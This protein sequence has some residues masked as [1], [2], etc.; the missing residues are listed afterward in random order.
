MRARQKAII[1]GT[2][3]ST[4]V[5]MCSKYTDVG[6]GLVDVCQNAAVLGA[7]GRSAYHYPDGTS[8]TVC[9]EHAPP[10]NDRSYDYCMYKNH[11]DARQAVSV[12]RR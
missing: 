9:E 12:T 11:E 2:V 6:G 4:S 3:V 10:P 8:Q 5:L 7:G 1:V